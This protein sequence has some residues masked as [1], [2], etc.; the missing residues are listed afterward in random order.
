MPTAALTVETDELLNHPTLRVTL[1]VLLDG[2]GYE[3][4][5]TCTGGDWAVK[6]VGRTP[7]LA[8]AKLRLA[9]LRGEL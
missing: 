7:E 8:L 3:A 2:S 1:R 4:A 6:R 9:K 5:Y